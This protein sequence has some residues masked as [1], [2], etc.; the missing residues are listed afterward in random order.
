MTQLAIG[1][2]APLGAHYDGQGRQLH[3]FSPLMPSG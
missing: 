2:P 3:T 1:K